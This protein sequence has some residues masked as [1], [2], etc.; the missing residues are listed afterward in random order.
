MSNNPEILTYV[1]FAINGQ[2]NT[3]PVDHVS[4]TD[5][6]LASQ[7]GGWPAIC[8]IP[9][10]AGGQP[11]DGMDLNGYLY[12]LSL[13]TVHRQSGK[14]MQFDAEYA[15]NIGGYSKGALLQS[16]DLSTFWISTADK[17]LT[18]P[19]SSSASN[20]KQFAYTPIATST[21]QGTVKLADTLNSTAKDTALTANQGSVLN[22][23]IGNLASSVGAMFATSSMQKNGYFE[24][25]DVNGNVVMMWQWGTVDYDSYPSELQYNLT[26]P[27][28]FPKNCLTVIPARKMSQHSSNGDG[29]INVVG[30][31]TNTGAV[32]SLQQYEGNYYY[33][34]RGFTWLAIGN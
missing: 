18:D 26:F 20:W 1:P 19:D 27:Q 14:V 31:P 5:D 25:K 7:R 4:G 8:L 3:V 33:D 13:D 28:P 16:T 17:N 29:G 15:S 2:K 10:S 32:F 11:P 23:Q 30:T 9:K 12:Q 22:T 24:I 34:L 6:R 21:T